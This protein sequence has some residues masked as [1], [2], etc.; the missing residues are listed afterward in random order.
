MK[1]DSVAVIHNHFIDS[2]QHINEGL[3][4]TT[5]Y[6]RDFFDK[7]CNRVAFKDRDT[8]EA[9]DKY[10]QVVVYVIVHNHE[11]VFCYLRDKN[12]DREQELYGKLGLPSGHIIPADYH[13][14]GTKSL[15]RTVVAA[16]LRVV[17]DELAYLPQTPDISKI[18]PKIMGIIKLSDTD[19]D[20]KHIGIVTVLN[21]KLLPKKT[22]I[23]GRTGNSTGQFLD[24]H[25]WKPQLLEN[26]L[27]L[28]VDRLVI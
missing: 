6:L 2:L 28:L 19:I 9:S 11:E 22:I 5:W 7:I 14:H 13:R 12:S 25:D 27:K 26:W 21:T 20:R 3:T 23:T 10:R 24:P 4:S 15:I 17:M 8:M 18:H 16:T 1:D